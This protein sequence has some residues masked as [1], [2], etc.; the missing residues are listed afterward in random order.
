MQQYAAHYINLISVFASS[1]FHVNMCYAAVKD[2]F[3][4]QMMPHILATHDCIKY[5]YSNC[6]QQMNTPRKSIKTDMMV[7]LSLVLSRASQF[8]S[9]YE[10]M[11]EVINSLISGA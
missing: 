7:T 6:K 4:Q 5:F 9:V 8:L 11:Y 1:R 2:T 10:V 3:E